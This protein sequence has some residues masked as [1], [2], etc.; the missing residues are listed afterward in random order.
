MDR[1][2]KLALTVLI[3]TGITLLGYYVLNSRNYETYKSLHT[4]IEKLREQ[5]DLLKKRNFEL[6]QQLKASRTDDHFIEKRVRENLG[7]VR[8]DEILFIFAPKEKIHK[9]PDNVTKDGPKPPSWQ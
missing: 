6:R 3:I 7:L 9:L 4:E 8:E 5:N 2:R 1:V